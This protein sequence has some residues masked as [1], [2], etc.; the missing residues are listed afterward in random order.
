MIINKNG[1]GY[2]YANDI[3]SYKKQR[4]GKCCW[5]GGH[6]NPVQVVDVFAASQIIE[7]C[8]LGQSSKL[9]FFFMVIAES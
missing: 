5:T 7:V 3:M 2:V 4:N 8:Y 9:C 6:A 1:G